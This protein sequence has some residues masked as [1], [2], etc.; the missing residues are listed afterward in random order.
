MS[1][2]ERFWNAI[3]DRWNGGKIPFHR[4]HPQQQMM[5]IQGINAILSVLSQPQDNG[6]M[7]V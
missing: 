7:D 1:D 3:Q 4:L 6:F 5:F 2:V